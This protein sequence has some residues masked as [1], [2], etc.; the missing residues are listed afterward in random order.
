MQFIEGEPSAPINQYN[1]LIQKRLSDIVNEVDDSLLTD[2]KLKVTFGTD[3][4][5]LSTK[6]I[7]N[8]TIKEFVNI[9]H[10][11]AKKEIHNTVTQ[12]VATVKDKLFE[13]E[14]VIK[15]ELAA[16]MDDIQMA[17]LEHRL[18]DYNSQ[19]MV[20]RFWVVKP[21][22]RNTVTVAPE[23]L[24]EEIAKMVILAIVCERGVP[25]GY[26]PTTLTM[27]IPTANY[28][29]LNIDVPVQI[30]ASAIR[31]LVELEPMLDWEWEDGKINDVMLSKS[32]VQEN[33]VDEFTKLH[34]NYNAA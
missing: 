21:T 20:N 5:S 2:F 8:A 15:H 9:H 24:V 17:L 27:R 1:L 3:M 13:M 14:M 30:R 18:K 32:I 7:N 11:N 19:S 26:A 16:R 6:L 4:E 23:G 25:Y 10:A 12:H 33:A 34:R 22:K 28:G 29:I 31:S